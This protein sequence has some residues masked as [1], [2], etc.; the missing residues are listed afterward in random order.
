MTKK[1]TIKNQTDFFSNDADV[2]SKSSK[3]VKFG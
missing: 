1:N 3:K 2:K